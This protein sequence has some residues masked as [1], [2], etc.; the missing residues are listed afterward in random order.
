MET[1]RV[2]WDYAITYPGAAHLPP[3]G[4]PHPG[5]SLSSHRVEILGLLTSAA[6]PSPPVKTFACA[7]VR[8]MR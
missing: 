5:D 2:L 1:D 7:D 4:F 8:M 6:R 3:G